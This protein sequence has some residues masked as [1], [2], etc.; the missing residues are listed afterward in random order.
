MLALSARYG[1]HAYDDSLVNLRN[2]RQTVSLQSYMEEFDELYPRA[3]VKES[4]TLSFFLS[5]LMNELQIPVKMFKPKTLVD[6]SSLAHFK[7]IAIVALHNKPKPTTKNPDI[8][9]P[10][11]QKSYDIIH[12][13]HLVP[14]QTLYCPSTY[15]LTNYPKY[16]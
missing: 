2:L 9:H 10:Y 12:P 11:H 1:Q 16:T 14:N 6:A 15:H 7:E 3:E 5:S 13:Y 4:H 8:I